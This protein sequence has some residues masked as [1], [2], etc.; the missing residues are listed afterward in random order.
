MKKKC[1]IL[2]PSFYFLYRWGDWLCN[3]KRDGS[4]KFKPLCQK[5]RDSQSFDE[6]TTSS[7]SS[8]PRPISTTTTSGS[9]TSNSGGL[10][11]GCPRNGANPSTLQN[12]PLSQTGTYMY[13]VHMYVYIIIQ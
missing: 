7:P 12:P 8:T 6:V 13:R 9:A 3:T 4:H 1:K 5:D 10:T 11:D 2:T